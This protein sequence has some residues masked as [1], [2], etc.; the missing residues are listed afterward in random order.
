MCVHGILLSPA[1]LRAIIC[2][3]TS[4]LPADLLASE[5]AAVASGATTLSHRSVISSATAVCPS[6]VIHATPFLGRLAALPLV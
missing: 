1:G 2:S 4:V 3:T 5:I 6:A